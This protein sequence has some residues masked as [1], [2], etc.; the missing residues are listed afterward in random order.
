MTVET[1]LTTM[2]SAELTM[3]HARDEI[4]AAEA[5]KQSRMAKK[6]MRPRGFGR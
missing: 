1:L 2:S 5:E 3:W 6:G 4:K